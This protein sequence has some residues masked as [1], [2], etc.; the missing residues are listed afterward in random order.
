MRDLAG[1]RVVD[2]QAS[3]TG[4]VLVVDDEP[5][6]L[7]LLGDLLGHAG[8][9]VMTAHDGAS[10][11]AKID[12]RV[13]DVLL[14]DVLMP[15]KS[16]YDVCRELRARP[17]CAALPIVLVT[18]LDADERIKGL[19]AGADELL[20]KPIVAPELLARVRRLVRTKQLYDRV[21]RQA[22]HLRRMNEDLGELVD[23]KVGEIERLSKLKRF[24]APKL[25]ERVVTGDAGD[26]WQL[27]RRDIVV[28]FFDLRGFTAF[29]EV[30]A[31]E[32]VMAVLREFHARVGA[33]TLRY[34]GTIE[35][36]AGDGIM[37]FFN[38]PE[39]V[40]KPC[41]Q[42][43]RFARSALDVCAPSLEQWRRKGFTIDISAGAAYG[44]ATLGAIG[45]EDRMDYGAIGPVTNL[46][47][48]L[49]AE[50][51]GGEI[52]IDSRLAAELPDNYVLEPCGLFSLKGFR[53]PMSGYRL[54][55]I[56]A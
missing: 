52:L 10:A 1:T 15:G 8:F 22:F 33:E 39:P 18:A 11:I 9:D 48:R 24:L 54:T 41:E 36:F 56:K 3:D 6:N 42:A 13:P 28:V 5:A 12:M 4:L 46:A 2:Q 38:D 7:R 16:G 47:S 27:H 30:S 45:F 23:Q 40:P 21:E 44:Y 25:A 32:E 14:L 20:T 37:V 35:R 17:D 26:P 34:G 50:A 53:E 19:E 31:P 51:I 29:S 55:G 43:V 49:C